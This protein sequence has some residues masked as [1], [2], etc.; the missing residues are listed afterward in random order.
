MDPAA[1]TGST[2][3]SR[4]VGYAPRVRRH[5]HPPGDGVENSTTFFVPEILPV[6]VDLRYRDPYVFDS[7]DLL[8]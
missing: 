4:S 7:R 5:R 1:E 8:R 3:P 2:T 6:T